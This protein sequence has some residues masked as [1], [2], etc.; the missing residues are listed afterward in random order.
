MMGDLPAPGAGPPPAAR[1]LLAR[2]AGAREALV[3]VALSAA[4]AVAIGSVRAPAAD[5]AQR[6]AETSDVYVLPPTDEVVAL[7]LGYRSALADL[8]WSHVL[9]SQGM[10]TMERRRFE[11]LTLLLDAINALDPTF[12]DPYLFADALITFQTSETPHREVVKAREIMER[13][14]QNRPLDGEI[15]LALGQFV[16]F[17][18]PAAYLT[19]P[20]EKAQWRL[21]GARMLARAAELGGGD[22]NISWQALGGAGI[23]GR[24]GEREAQIRFLQRTLAVTDDEELKQKIRAQLDKLLDA[25]DAEKYRR[26]LDGFRDLWRRDLPFVSNT[27]ILVLG[28]PRDPA[29]CAGGAHADE[30]RCATTWRAWAERVE[31]ER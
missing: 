25:R 30:P 3:A 20:Q 24:A 11:N 12:R 9:V 1:S 22:A 23:L 31:G 14:V 2:L 4:A 6:V 17:I 29:Y 15:W 26:R 21:D 27:A 8:L 16:G 28:P 5:L 18:A 13:G 10:H 19:D 7:S